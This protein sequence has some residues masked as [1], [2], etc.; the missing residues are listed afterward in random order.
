MEDNNNLLFSV[1]SWIIVVVLQVLVHYWFSAWFSA[2]KYM[3]EGHTGSSVDAISLSEPIDASTVDFKDDLDDSSQGSARSPR[4]EVLH[5]LCSSHKQQ[6]QQHLQPEDMSSSSFDGN[7]PEIFFEL[8]S[9]TGC[10]MTRVSLHGYVYVNVLLLY[11]VPSYFK[12]YSNASLLFSVIFCR[13]TL[14]RV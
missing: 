11:R 4:E 5:S 2:R 6:N 12:G 10:E 13:S 1:Y 9:Q 8:L 14:T 3:N 7:E